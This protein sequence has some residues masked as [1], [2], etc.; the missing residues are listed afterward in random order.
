MRVFAPVALAS[1]AVMLFFWPWA[2][3]APIA[4]PLAALATFSHQ[5]FPYPTLFAGSYMLPSKLPWFYL[6][7]Y[8]LIALPE[9]WC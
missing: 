7:V 8:I 6:P 1:Y 9:N 3:E 2:Q 4:H 5:A